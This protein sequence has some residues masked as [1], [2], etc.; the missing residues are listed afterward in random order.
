MN[1]EL[2]IDKELLKN[3]S[4]KEAKSLELLYAEKESCFQ[5]LCKEKRE[6]FSVY[7]SGIYSDK[8]SDYSISYI[9][10]PDEPFA[11]SSKCRSIYGSDAKSK[12]FIRATADFKN[13]N[14]KVLL[15]LG[16]FPGYGFDIDGGSIMAGQLIDTLKNRC[17]LSVVFIRKNEETFSD[18]QVA[19]VRY[20]KYIDPWNN[21]FLRRL[22]NF[23]TNQEAMDNHSEYDIIIA[24]HISKFFGFSEYSNFFWKK[25]VLFPMFCS[26]SYI[27]AGEK[28]PYEYVKREQEVIDRVNKVITPSFEEQTDLVND[29]SCKP[30][31]IVVIPRGISPFIKYRHRKYVHSPLRIVCIGT[32]KKQK[33][34]KKTLEL[35]QI[36]EKN[37]I[38]CELHLVCTIQDQESR[39][40]YKELCCMIEN[41]NISQ[42]I[43]F[44]ISISQSELANLLTE[45]DINVSMSNW[46]TFGRG[47]F[48]GASAGLPT[49]VFDV[50][51]TVKRL[52]KGNEGI[53]LHHQWIICQ[54][55]YQ[56]CFLIITDCIP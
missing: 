47:I 1:V 54:M 56:R 4:E 36:L 24:A 51:Q 5:K 33:N 12:A 49:F 34:T 39:D 30:E 29:Y 40:S 46:E 6:C 2:E 35:I 9:I 48:E 22:E 32:I 10:N 31:K 28:V 52:S 7:I 42:K 45:M 13:I 26:N 20:V 43:N 14:K 21:K 17:Q 25:T 50:L 18:D 41:M 19:S 16:K 23:S 55:K 8:V 44:H 3:L 38:E 15:Y 37:G 53:F 27:R 11:E